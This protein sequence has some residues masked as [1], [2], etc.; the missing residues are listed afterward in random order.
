MTDV[1]MGDP[2]PGNIT[3]EDIKKMPA[4]K[5]RK[6]IAL[7]GIDSVNRRLSGEDPADETEDEESR[8]T[9]VLTATAILFDR[10]IIPK[11]K[12]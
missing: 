4:K 7:Y 3:V 8:V 9:N 5:I 10:E 2:L 6:L 11:E 12:A 1:R